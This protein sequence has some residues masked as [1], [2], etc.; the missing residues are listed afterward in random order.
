M[1]RTLTCYRCDRTYAP[2]KG[3]RCE[4]GEPLWFDPAGASIDHDD[5]AG[6]NGDGT[7]ETPGLWRYGASLPVDPPPGLARGVG[8]T[9]LIGADHLADGTDIRIYVKDEPQ[10]P[11]GSYKDRGSAV[12][13]PLAIETP[14]GS[15]EHASTDPIDAVGTVSYG[16]MAMSTA[17]HAASLGI[18]CVVLVPTDTPPE[19]LEAIGQYDPTILQVEGAYGALYDDALELSAELPI[20]FLLS[21]A[22][23]RISGYSTV[24]DEII[25]QMAPETPDAMVVP[26]SSGGFACGI[27]HGLLRLEAAGALSTLPRLCVVQPAASDPITRV[28]EAD[29]EEVVPIGPEERAETIARSVGN[30][31]PP[32]GTRTL[33]AIEHTDGAAVSVSDEAILR[34]QERFARRGGFCVE[35]AAALP[36]AGLDRLETRGTIEE[37]DRVVLIPTGTGFKEIGTAGTSASETSTRGESGT[38]SSTAGASDARSSTQRSSTAGASTDA[39]VVTRSSLRETIEAV[40]SNGNP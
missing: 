22:P 11:T 15:I 9:P 2:G 26:A 35:P 7:I 4:C 16:N 14:N 32:S 34:A 30:P 18:E 19:R 23:G 12:A 33:A 5:P 10:N 25:A 29:R 17:A 1:T 38:R 24:V 39:R 37:G 13:V 31:D 6:G 40:L 8:G 36:L 20:E 27:W 21:D 28:F 3:P